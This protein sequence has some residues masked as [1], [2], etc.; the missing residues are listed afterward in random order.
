MMAQQ[1]VEQLTAESGPSK[2]AKSQ[3]IWLCKAVRKVFMAQP[4]L[5]QLR[6]PVTICGDIHGQY[7]DL[8]QI[9]RQAKY[10]PSTNYL[11]LG[12]YVDRGNQG[13]PVVC[14]L[15]ALKIL[16]PEQVFLLRGNHEC[17]YINQNFGFYDECIEMYD[18]DI[19]RLFSDV[20]NCL[21][22]CAVIDE[23][24]FCV[25]GGISPSLKS[26]DQI[27]NL[28]RPAEVP[29]Q[30]LLCDILW[31]DPD[32]KIDDWE[33]ND[34]GTSYVYGRRASREFLDQFKFDLICRAHQAVMPGYDFPFADDRSV[35]TVFSA[36]N[37]GKVF[38][39]KAAILH[40]DDNL[41]CSFSI[42]GADRAQTPRRCK[43]VPPPSDNA[44]PKTAPP[45]SDNAGSKTVP[46]PSDNARP[47]TAPPPSD[48]AGSKTTAQ[49]SENV[50]PMKK[51]THPS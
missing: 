12:D 47:K 29:E 34:R 43:I 30:G 7:S 41:V 32:P 18:Y 48:K 51:K 40:V 36:A 38:G 37:Y 16:F 46:P 31:S 50:R 10:P 39:N 6:P 20:F 9:F 15:F 4:M 3:I 26:L 27:R 17:T 14:L 8:L 22:V 42:V 45:P 13:I 49:P 35:V 19:W 1:M 33:T 21:P 44:R 23:R 11:F 25:H 28:R 2:L 5:L 24:I